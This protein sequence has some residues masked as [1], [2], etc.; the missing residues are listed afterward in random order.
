MK[1]LKAHRGFSVIGIALYAVL[2]VASCTSP[3]RAEN[4]PFIVLA[5][6]TIAVDLAKII[7]TALN[8]RERFRTVGV[9][10]ALFAQ[11]ITTTVFITLLFTLIGPRAG[12]VPGYVMV[13]V[14]I[15]L[16]FAE[17]AQ[18]IKSLFGNNQ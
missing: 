5:A 4:L 18:C 8:L 7:L 12:D 13:F 14:M 2:L 16:L 15:F 9:L 6:L 1:N 11:T 3:S 10:T 17:F